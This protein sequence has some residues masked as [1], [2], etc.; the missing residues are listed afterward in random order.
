MSALLRT[1][2]APSD[3]AVLCVVLVVFVLCVCVAILTQP[4]LDLRGF[5]ASKAL[6]PA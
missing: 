6:A 1:A 2:I 3:H 4:G 5:A